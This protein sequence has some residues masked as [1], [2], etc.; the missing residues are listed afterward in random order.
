[1]TGHS[2]DADSTVAAAAPAGTK[3]AVV[4]TCFNEGAYI[5][6]A[7]RS[8]LKQTRADLIESIV[9]A[10]DGSDSPTVRVLESIEK[11]DSRIKVVYGSGGNGLP[12]QRNLAIAATS[13]P[14]VAILDGDD[15]WSRQ[16]LEAMLPAL[17]DRAVG[18]VYSGYYA[19]GNDDVATAHEARVRD[20]TRDGDL[21]R[22]FFLNDP[23]IIPSTVVL[24]RSAFEC[25]GGF[26]SSIKVFEDTDL[27]IRLSRICR[28]AFVERPLLYKR[29]R[30]TSVTNSRKDLMA[31]HSLVALKAAGD[32]PR[33]LALVPRRLAERARKLGNHRF[34]LGDSEGAR[35]LLRFAV[36]LDPANAN[37]WGAYITVRWFDAPV[38]YMLSGRLRAR[39][40][41]LG[42]QQH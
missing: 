11:W 26:D 27:Y 24:R 3:V 13:A 28:F 16:K 22:A 38:R 41:A 29:S 39:R 23:P 5:G 8:V 30:A 1:M 17:K 31:F 32:E 36:R 9:I 33:L 15:I 21:T 10:D 35:Q 18:L 42:V 14:L 25:V 20:I 2:H 4:L 19:F 6:E 34:L 7:V 12:A 40:L 37:A